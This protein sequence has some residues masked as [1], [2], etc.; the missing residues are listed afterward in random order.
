MK[1]LLLLVGLLVLCL[2][3]QLHA[4]TVPCPN[5]TSF[6]NLLSFNSVANGCFS[7]DALFWGFNYTPGPNAPAANAV[8][9]SVISQTS[10]ALAIHGW[11]FDGTW[12]QGN[13]A[14]ALANFTL[15][16]TFEICPS[17]GQSCSP[18]VGPGTVIKGAD[19]TYAPVSIFP[20][21]KEDVSWSNGAIVT[22]TSAFPG[23]EPPGGNIGL[24]PGFVGPITVTANFSGTGAITQTSLRFYDSA[25]AVP[26]PKQST[27]MLIGLVCLL[28]SVAIRRTMSVIDNALKANR[29]YAKRH[30]IQ[31]SGN[32]QL[33]KTPL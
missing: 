18:N 24:A 10:P 23:A 30:D 7:Q 4:A 22:L 25:S 13:S 8:T 16:Y 15:G 19:A 33:A 5:T 26:E 29:E 6:D 27:F 28:A 17:S 21:G 2:S 32:V 31:G 1:R 11:N 20:P 14:A 3:A 12:A 9:A